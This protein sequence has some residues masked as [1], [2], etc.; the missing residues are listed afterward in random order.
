VTLETSRV[1][2]VLVVIGGGALLIAMGVDTLAVAGRHLGISLLGSIEIVQAAVLVSGATAILVAT[3][4]GNHARVRLVAERA[5]PAL[6]NVMDRAGLLCSAL[7]FLALAS[8]SCWLAMD[9]W[10]GQEESELLHLAYRPLRV[11]TVLAMAAVFV[12]FVAR[13]ISGKSR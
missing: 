6:R 10:N 9:L 1:G 2:R 5:S 7:F 3:L 12:V 13:G 11:F 8:G 4:A